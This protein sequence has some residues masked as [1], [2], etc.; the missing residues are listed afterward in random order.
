MVPRTHHPNVRP[1]TN[2]N[3]TVRQRTNQNRI[4]R[5]RTVRDRIVDQSTNRLHLSASP[6]RLIELIGRNVLHYGTLDAY[7][8][9]ITGHTPETP[10]D[11]VCGA[12]GQ[13]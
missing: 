12:I 9:T 6:T 5:T 8:L 4:I 2:R 7:D 3:R 13:A 11:A 10:S 1:R